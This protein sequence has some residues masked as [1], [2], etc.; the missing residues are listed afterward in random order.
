MKRTEYLMLCQRASLFDKTSVPHKLLV[1]YNE[2]LY[3][4]KSYELGFTKG[5]ATH[6]AILQDRFSNSEIVANLSKIEQFDK[7]KE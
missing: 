6:K 2:T 1:K 5:N 3:V 7:M 4:P